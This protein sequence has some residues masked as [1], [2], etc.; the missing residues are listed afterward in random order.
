MSGERGVGG[1]GGFCV[2]R[3]REWGMASTLGAAREWLLGEGGG[4][5]APRA[6]GVFSTGPGL[7]AVCLEGEVQLWESRGGS[8]ALLGAC[9]RSQESLQEDGPHRRACWC[10]RRRNLA[11]LAPG[12]TIFLYGLARG[13]AGRRGPEVLLLRALQAPPGLG[14]P[15]DPVI[16]MVCAP[17]WLLLCSARGE[18]HRLS[19]QGTALPASRPLQEDIELTSARLCPDLGV[20]A[21]LTA[22]GAAALL[23][24]GRDIDLRGR[25]PLRKD[26]RACCCDFSPD[27]RSLAV[28]TA[29]GSIVVFR[30]GS[31]REV[32]RVRS[33][34]LGD[35]GPLHGLPSPV[36]SVSWSPQGDLVAGKRLSGEVN[37]W[38]AFGSL[39][40]ADRQPRGAG[41][42]GCSRNGGVREAERFEEARA[43]LRRE[44][45]EMELRGS[46]TVWGPE[47]LQLFALGNSNDSLLGGADAAE[48]DMPYTSRLRCFSFVKLCHKGYPRYPVSW[49]EA[50]E[51]PNQGILP[52]SERLVALM[53]AE[54]RVLGVTVP[55]PGEAEISHTMPPSRYMQENWPLRL[56][57]C[58]PRGKIA[59]GG[60]R[61]LALY[62]PAEDTWNI[63]RDTHSAP[64]QCHNIGWLGNGTHIALIISRD[65]A[66]RGVSVDW[67]EL[68]KESS[69]SVRELHVYPCDRLDGKALMCEHSFAEPVHAFDCDGDHALVLSHG[70]DS[71]NVL[72]LQIENKP[73]KTSKMA[74]TPWTASICQELLMMTSRPPPKYAAM[75]FGSCGET[76][77]AERP[78]AVLVLHSDWELCLLDL[79]TGSE[80]H[81]KSQVENF[82]LG[83]RAGGSGGLFTGRE[84]VAGAVNEADSSGRQ[85]MEERSGATDGVQQLWAYGSQGMH[86]FMLMPMVDDVT[87]HRQI[88]EVKEL[89]P[90]LEFDLEVYPV[91]VLEGNFTVVGISPQIFSSGQSALH[92]PQTRSQSIL[93][94]TLRHHLRQRTPAA[95]LHRIAENA[96]WHPH[97]THSLE[98]LVHTLL[99]DELSGPATNPKGHH[100]D[101]LSLLEAAINLVRGF[102][103]FLEVVVRVARKTDPQQ[104]PTLFR[105]T[106][107]PSKLL[108]AAARTGAYKTA[109]C[110]LVVVET[111]EGADAGQDCALHLLQEVL[112]V[113]QYGVTGDLVRFLVRSARDM[114]YSLDQT[115]T[116]QP[117]SKIWQGL[118]KLGLTSQE[119][120]R[121][122]VLKA[123]VHKI[124]SHHT[125]LLLK[126]HD[127]RSLASFLRNT[128]FDII[129]LLRESNETCGD[130]LG[131]FQ[132]A[133]TEVE[134]AL[135]GDAPPAGLASFDKRDAALLMGT[136]REAGCDELVVVFATA[137]RLPAVLLELF[138]D[139]REMFAAYTGSLEGRPRYAGLLDALN[140][141]FAAPADPAAPAG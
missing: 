85:E 103:D 16:E 137:L 87:Q 95:R 109:C 71:L 17:S 10:P 104:W 106:G 55:A 32:E 45:R 112:G 115:A 13:V 117:L 130:N 70:E 132:L 4:A 120:R 59:V 64:L 3:G 7:L 93:S 127:Y 21:V 121:E 18:L 29:G 56:A 69:N 126:Q 72:T 79:G 74:K 76:E 60:E 105:H 107:L 2:S 84:S 92:A 36:M 80:R 62:E 48:G 98:W 27:T 25:L 43:V 96:Q 113:R 66:D 33:I 46:Q 134:E 53:M 108:E 102:P 100:A 131:T 20:L 140:H 63:F 26:E 110:Y 97:F 125:S 129:P 91:A 90:E 12:G 19:W 77:G 47:G 116:S 67:R 61:G 83:H 81:L 128:G 40:L 52:N 138:T 23:S 141:A 37:T 119:S 73:G 78:Q 136:F 57:T 22:R 124:L 139:D 68:S 114:Q 44:A 111:L 135:N 30:L 118:T 122:E 34:T 65:S 5:P 89:G 14:A 133:L 58:S 51:D 123:T 82:W 94:A 24:V 39:I 11:A 1:Q 42:E 35:W 101:E 8:P 75:V 9:R 99:E 88:Q 6:A 15:A 31:S 50:V 86:A 28:G 38:R 49:R 54:D 41:Q